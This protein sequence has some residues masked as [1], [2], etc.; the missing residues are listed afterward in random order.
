M[1]RDVY[2]HEFRADDHSGGNVRC[3]RCLVG[4]DSKLAQWPCD[5]AAEKAWE[6]GMR[7]PHKSTEVE[8]S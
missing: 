3:N 8:E 6:R 7:D 4:R 5:A 2:G 1:T